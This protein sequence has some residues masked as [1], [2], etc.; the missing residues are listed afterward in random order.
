[1]INLASDPW[2][3]KILGKPAYR[4]EGP[5]AELERG[6]LPRG[7]ALVEARV[8]A[9][10]A[11]GLFVLQSL[12]FRVVDSNIAMYRPAHHV[13]SGRAES[14]LVDRAISTDELE[15]RMLAGNAFEQNRF[16]RDPEISKAT[17]AR[18]KEEW[19]GNYFL[20]GRGDWMYVCRDRAGI[21]GFLQLIR[22]ELDTV[23]IDLIAV[24]PDRQRKGLARAMIEHAATNCLDGPANMRVGTQLGNQ[25]SLSLY[26]SIGFVFGSASYVLHRHT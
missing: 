17:A 7:A 8:D 14:V 26:Q 11:E 19:A 12:G 16:H 15:V 3:S 24:A 21:G 1:M 20:G 5:T 2:L 4:F 13:R 25:K 9:S 22:S 18:I 23:V 6:H 10:D